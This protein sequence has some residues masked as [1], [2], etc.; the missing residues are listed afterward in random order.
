MRLLLARNPRDNALPIQLDVNWAAK[1]VALLPRKRQGKRVT[2]DGDEVEAARVGLPR[3]GH[4]HL[5][6]DRAG[7]AH[8]VDHELERHVRAVDLLVLGVG[9]LDPVALFRRVDFYVHRLVRQT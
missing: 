6:H 5:A 3:P 8:P 1:R 7:G 9:V 2:G 4:D